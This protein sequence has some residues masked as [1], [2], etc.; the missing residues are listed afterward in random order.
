MLLKSYG[1]YEVEVHI[2]VQPTS[3]CMGREN[4][5]EKPN[6]ISKNDSCGL[7]YCF[8][9]KVISVGREIVKNC[10]STHLLIYP[11]SLL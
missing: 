8:P 9:I 10:V 6:Q 2:Q 4:Q 11:I 1:F 5:Q 3:E 7:W